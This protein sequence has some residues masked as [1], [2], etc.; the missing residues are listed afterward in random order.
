MIPFHV[1]LANDFSAENGG[2]GLV[3]VSGQDTR[4]W[5]Y[6]CLVNNSLG[7]TS[8]D[9]L[10]H[11]RIYT[12]PFGGNAYDQRFCGLLIMTQLVAHGEST[13]GQAAGKR[14][15][16][17][18]MLRGLICRDDTSPGATAVAVT[19][20]VCAVYRQYDCAASVLAGSP[21]I[22]D[23]IWPYIA[24]DRSSFMFTVIDDE[25]T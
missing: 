14:G 19:L 16:R 13:A 11:A 17:G 18:G 15:R 25:K 12:P 1:H 10:S 3:R 8:T 7:S 24:I 22:Q 4:L 6:M 20:A 23:L 21:R 5:D 2:N 9:C